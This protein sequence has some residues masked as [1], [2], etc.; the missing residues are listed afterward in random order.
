MAGCS[1]MD[2]GRQVEPIDLAVAPAELA[3]SRLLDV[4]LIEFSPGLPG[5]NEKIPD[6]VFPEIR[7]AEARYFPYHLK[8]TL[9]QT[10]QWGAVRVIP[11]DSVVV[12]LYVTG[13]II[14]SNGDVVRVTLAAHD[15]RGE[16][17]IERR[18]SMRTDR[19]AY[20]R[21]RDRALDPY[22]NVYNEFAN[23]LFAEVSELSDEEIREIRTTSRMA[24]F[25]DMAPTV[26][27]DYV[28]RNRRGGVEVVRLP[29]ENDPM[30]D[31]LGAIRQRDALFLDTLNEHYANFYYGIALPYE[32]WRKSSREAEI[33]YQRIRRSAFLR[34]LA[35]VAIIA[36][37]S[38]I[39]R[40]D[41]G[42]S[43][44][45]RRTR[46]TMKDFAIYGGLQA[47]QSGFGRLADAR[48]QQQSIAELADSF[49]QEAAP[50]VV[51]V[52]GQTRRLSG[53]ASAQYDQWRDLLRR[54]NEA[55][56][57]L[58]DASDIGVPERAHE[59]LSD[60]EF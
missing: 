37:A 21:Q 17:W 16:K 2:T 12:D 9:E 45:E 42:D 48:L 4:G 53:T 15:I 7:R 11:D 58:A 23:D 30:V 56:L 10:G 3:E 46:N 57:G 47:I 25:A 41:A 1:T 20:S 54:I 50:M 24:F 19:A 60:A 22:Q 6:D 18:Y 27:G 39:N 38:E 13:R 52:Q 32:D 34:G 14:E 29:A 55:E 40:G 49:G 8:K 33:E 35:G 26:F 44:T 51:E 5:K 36:A 31:R 28:E 43:R 59:D